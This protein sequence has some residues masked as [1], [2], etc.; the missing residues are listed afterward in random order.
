MPTALRLPYPPLVLVE[1][2]SPV[3]WEFLKNQIGNRLSSGVSICLLATSGDPNRGGYFFHFKKV[4]EMIV[5]STFDKHEA[6]SFNNTNDFT[7]FVN[8]ASGRKYSSKM[9][10]LSQFVNL[11]TDTENQ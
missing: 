6:L 2:D 1:S 11:R 5:L 3:E 4:K 7:E 9:W 8:H 10:K